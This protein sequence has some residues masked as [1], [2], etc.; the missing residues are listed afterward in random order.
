MTWFDFA[1]LAVLALSVAWGVWRGLVHE[2][3][4]LGGWV[5][6]FLAANLL[7]GPLSEQITSTMRPE[8]RVLLAWLGIFVVVLLG[9]SLAGMLLGRFIKSV[10]LKSTDRTLGGLFGLVRGVVMGLAFA[11]LAGLTRFPAHP[12][13]KDSFF[14]PPLGNTIVQLKPWLPPA[15]AG[16]LRY[17]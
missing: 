8:L 14:G 4:S 12:A 1:F 2:M 5:L 13:W 10:G 17:N 6:A 16:R 9:A 7:S 11:L 3:L 15:L